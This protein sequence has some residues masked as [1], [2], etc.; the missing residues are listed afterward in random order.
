MG[1]LI[2]EEE[3]YIILGICMEIH[4]SLGPGF[5]EPVYKEAMD[6]EFEVK[7]VP[8]EKERK[9]QIEYTVIQLR[10][11]FFVDYVVFGKIL[12]EVKATSAH[13]ASFEAQTLNYLKASGMKVALIVNF[14]QSSLQYK[15]LI[16]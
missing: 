2:Y 10:K 1:K 7:E 12:L 4:K 9:F 8:F 3:T 15:R 6:Y 16:I 14:G 5:Q 11:K 13:H